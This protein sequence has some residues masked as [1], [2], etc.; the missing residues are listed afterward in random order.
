MSTRAPGPGPR[1]V[2]PGRGR[3]PARPRPRPRVSRSRQARDP[4]RGSSP[5]L[6]AEPPDQVAGDPLGDRVPGP[7]HGLAQPA[8]ADRPARL[9]DRASV[10]RPGRPQGAPTL[11]AGRVR[12]PLVAIAQGAEAG[13]PG[14]PTRRAGR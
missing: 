5:E 14:A 6:V 13:A 10:S 11:V 4:A 8:P 7:G 2:C 3:P 9:L 1:T 12:D